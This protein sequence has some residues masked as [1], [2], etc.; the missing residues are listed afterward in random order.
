MKFR[1]RVFIDTKAV[2]IR[3]IG[4]TRRSIVQWA[5]TADEAEHLVKNRLHR[6]SYYTRTDKTKIVNRDVVKWT[7]WRTVEEIEAEKNAV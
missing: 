7:L 3:D 1:W 6:E 2:G 4:W 5:E